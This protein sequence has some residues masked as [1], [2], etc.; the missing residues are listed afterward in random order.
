MAR[1]ATLGGRLRM[2]NGVDRISL[3][4][5]CCSVSYRS[6]YRS[7]WIAA[8]EESYFLRGDPREFRTQDKKVSSTRVVASEGALCGPPIGSH[9]RPREVRAESVAVGRGKRSCLPGDRV[10]S[11]EAERDTEVPRQPDDGRPLLM[12]NLEFVRLPRCSCRIG[13]VPLERLP[14]P[15][16]RGRSC[17]PLTAVH[18]VGISD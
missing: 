13:A 6:R 10:R 3:P 2:G 14:Y 15:I 12:P 4:N 16:S 9:G 11:G 18:S 17:L 5:R 8:R 1:K 7:T